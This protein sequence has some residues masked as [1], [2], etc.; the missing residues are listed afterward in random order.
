[1]S[2]I[3]IGYLVFSSLLKRH[4]PGRLDSLAAIGR[5]MNHAVSDRSQRRQSFGQLHMADHHCLDGVG[6]QR[7]NDVRRSWATNNR[8][9][10]WRPRMAHRGD[11][12]ERRRQA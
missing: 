4:L 9:P 12:S 10:W 7:S 3:F 8:S 5:E 1:M 11:S 6:G 2:T